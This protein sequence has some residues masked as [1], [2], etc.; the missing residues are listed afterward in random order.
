MHSFLSAWYLA[1]LFVH[2]MP[3]GDLTACSGPQQEDC[4]RLLLRLQSAQHR[5]ESCEQ[6]KQSPAQVSSSSNKDSSKTCSILPEWPA[7]AQETTLA[8]Q[9]STSG[10]R[11][12]VATCPV[13][14]GSIIWTESP[15]A[16]VLLK[17]PRKQVRSL[18]T[19][20][21]RVQL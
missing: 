4:K 19:V 5:S 6:S 10:D 20:S 9:N 17:Q 7:D 14:A 13:A 18:S 8:V 16:H 11:Q 12:L 15:F 3:A 1:A 21:L 2:K